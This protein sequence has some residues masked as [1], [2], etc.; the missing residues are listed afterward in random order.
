MAVGKVFKYVERFWATISQRVALMKYYRHLNLA[1]SSLFILVLVGLLPQIVASQTA[2]ATFDLFATVLEVDAENNRVKIAALGEERFVPVVD[3]AR[4]LTDEGKP[5]PEGLNAPQ[6]KKGT[7]VTITVKP[8]NGQIGSIAAIQLGKHAPEQRRARGASIGLK[9]LTEFS[10]DEK[11][12]GED[13]GLYGAGRNLPPAEHLA[14]AKS[15]TGKIKP[16][17][18]RGKPADDGMIGFVSIS[19]SNATMEFSAFKKL[20]DQ[21]DGKSPRVAIVDCA[22]NGQAMALWVDPKA[23]AW[24]EAD[25]RLKAAEVSAEQVQ[26][27]WIKIANIWPTDQLSDHGRKLYDDTLAVIQNAK[28]RF[29]NLRVVYLGSRIYAGFAPAG[30]PGGL[31]PEPY[32]YEGAFVVRWLIRDQ[33][34]GVESLRYDGEPAPAPLLLWGPYLWAD[35]SNARRSDGLTWEREDFF[36]DGVHPSKSGCRKVADQFLDYFTTDTLAKSWFT[37]R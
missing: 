20:A 27:A 35:G 7:K 15:A 31:N 26:V 23:S 2:P 5:M 30:P 33:I 28:K 10:A 14:A 1:L 36:G 12:E 29:P 34:N 22:Q 24:R 37:N 6:F 18:M 32:A 25:R 13:G 17:S 9:P 21:H 8:S 11:Y 4:I 19:M 16:L 3:D